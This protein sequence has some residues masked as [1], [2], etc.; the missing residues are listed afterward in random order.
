MTK[1]ESKYFHTALLMDEAL[2]ELLAVKDFQFISVK[3]ICVKA[4]VNRSTFYLHYETMGDLLSETVAHIQREFMGAFNA[5]AKEFIEGIEKAPLDELLLITDEYLVPYLEFVK[6]HKPVYRAA[7]LNPVCM[8]NE[9]RLS[10]LYRYVLKPIFTRFGIPEG[11]QKYWLAYH[12]SG[13]GSIINEWLKGGCAEPV[14]DIV[15]VI[16]NCVRPGK[17]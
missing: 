3:E 5:D 11:E 2:I 13:I 10:S 7:A 12:I 1:S 9:A 15:R 8:E 14:E 6:A 4:G 17:H 16:E